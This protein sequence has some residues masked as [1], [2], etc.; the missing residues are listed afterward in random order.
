MEKQLKT[1][2]FKCRK[3]LQSIFKGKKVIVMDDAKD[4]FLLATLRYLQ[5][6]DF[7]LKIKI[8]LQTMCNTKARSNLSHIYWFC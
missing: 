4:T 1:M 8:W 6:P 3:L 7:G 5:I 2:T